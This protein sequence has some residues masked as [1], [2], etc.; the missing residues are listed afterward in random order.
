[1]LRA[2][3]F[4]GAYTYCMDSKRL[5]WLFVFIGGTIGSYIPVLW[6]DNAFSFASILCGGIGSIIGI[7][8]AF[9]LTH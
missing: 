1:M 8:V 6:G 9:K 5:M 4:C 3:S 7:Y 2:I